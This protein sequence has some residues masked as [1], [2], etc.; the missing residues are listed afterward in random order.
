MAE[1]VDRV[2]LP[3][4]V[5]SKSLSRRESITQNLRR[6]IKL[7]L[8][9]R[10]HSDD[11]HDEWCEAESNRLYHIFCDSIS[12]H[13]NHLT[14]SKK[15]IFDSRWGINKHIKK[16]SEEWH[17]K[18]D[19][20][21]TDSSISNSNEIIYNGIDHDA[22]DE[23]KSR[24]PSSSIELTNDKQLDVS[25][26]DSKLKHIDSE[27]HLVELLHNSRDLLTREMKNIQSESM[28]I[29]EEIDEHTA[30]AQGAEIMKQFFLDL[31]GRN[32]DEAKIFTSEFEKELK[33]VKAVGKTVKIIT[34]IFVL[35][36]NAYC[37]FA[38]ILYGKG[39]PISWH[40]TW[41]LT[42]VF[43][44]L[45]DVFMN[46]VLETYILTRLIPFSIY[47]K[48]LHL[49]QEINNL[50]AIIIKGL[51]TESNDSSSAANYELDNSKRRFSVTDFF[52]V[53]NIISKKHPD[54]PEGIVTYNY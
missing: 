33:P 45:A 2:S 23:S 19:T 21:T 30:H 36:F 51:I 41:L 52:F 14:D 6:A 48:T 31:I 43:N 47:S 1:S 42:F 18:V 53:S 11:G 44:L 46:N 50:A 15:E 49:Q 20:N 34:I 24:Y 12:E 8:K 3:S 4:A 40:K 7:P 39:Q 16:S 37:C 54:L 38:C 5:T 22:V 9:A 13:R 17:Q 10:V 35:I 25:N 27:N 28:T 26:D 32:S 29:S